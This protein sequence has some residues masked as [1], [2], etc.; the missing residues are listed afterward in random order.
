VP[1]AARG[2]TRPAVAVRADAWAAEYH[3]AARPLRTG[4]LAGFAAAEHAL[5]ALRRL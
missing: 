2:M 1:T 5:T 4:V 3:E